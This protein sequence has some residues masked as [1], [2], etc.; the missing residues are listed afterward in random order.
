MFHDND[1]TRPVTQALLRPNRSHDY[2]DGLADLLDVIGTNYRYNE[3]IAAHRA[4]PTRKIVGTENRHD[5][6][7]WLA[8]RDTPAYAGEFIWS[9]IDYLG[10]A[11]FWPNVASSSGLLDRT[12]RPRPDAYQ[13]QS[14]WSAAPMVFA[15]R[16]VA[17][18]PRGP[19][20]PGYGPVQHRRMQVLFPDW[21]PRDAS[22]HDETVEVYSNCAQVELLLNGKTLGTQ[23]LAADLAPRTWHVPYAPGTLRA[24][25]RNRGKVVATAELGTAGKPVRIQLTAERS[26]VSPDWDD[27]DYINA[28]I[29][30]ANGVVVPEAVNLVAFNV[31][32]PGEIVAVDSANNASHEPF[33]ARERHAFQGRCLAIIRATAPSGTITITA[34]APDLA[35]ASVNVQALAVTSGP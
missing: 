26:R 10:E 9:G 1:P 21:N 8:A 27:V 25:G 12:A 35:A 33:Q 5:L 30:D 2:D 32:G 14:W 19:A 31:S 3:L 6:A 24:V 13:V 17:P 29:V 22:P 20:D 23:N 34:T 28:A 15:A 7:S 18:T 16:R 11:W 4:R